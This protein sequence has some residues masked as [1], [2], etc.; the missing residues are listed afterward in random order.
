MPEE[1]EN[2]RSQLIELTADIVSA[3]VSKNPVPVASLPELIESVNSSLSKI[4]RPAEPEQPTQAPAVNP[5]RSVFP[6]YIICLEDGKQFK[7]LKRHLGVHYGM[8]PNEYREKWGLKPDY[9]MVAPNYAA[10]RSALAKSSGLGRKP[11]AKPSKST[12]KKRS[13]R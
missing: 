1:I 2:G 10:Q 7:S 11:A 13:L 9:P 3:Y 5:K 8:T 12:G 4:G 6:D